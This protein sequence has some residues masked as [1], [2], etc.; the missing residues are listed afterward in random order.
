MSETFGGVA[1]QVLQLVQATEP[2]LAGSPYAPRAAAIRE[3]L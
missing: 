3:R 1:G 2:S